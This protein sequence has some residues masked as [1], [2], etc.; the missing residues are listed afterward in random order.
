MKHLFVG[1]TVLLLV[2]L[3]GCAP[4]PVKMDPAFWSATGKTI[5]VAISKVPTP[6]AHKGG[7]QGLLDLA[8]NNAIAGPLELRLSTLDTHAVH[9]V[10]S[11]IETGLRERGQIPIKLKTIDIAKLKD[12]V[13][14]DN[15]DRFHKKDLR[16]L[17][18]SESVDVILLVQVKA[19]GTIRDYYG[20]IPTSTP[21]GYVYTE[22]S[23]VDADDNSLIWFEKISSVKDVEGQW[24]EPPNYKNLISSVNLAITKSANDIVKELFKKPSR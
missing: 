24:D 1:F 18:G 19:I 22:V 16:G 4:Q 21:A 7:S 5:G 8:I 23:M 12:F 6:T 10:F 11:K 2:A 9:A 3:T 20:F 14:P 17:V 13:G 15:Q